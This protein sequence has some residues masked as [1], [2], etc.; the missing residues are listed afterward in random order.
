M[1]K[2]LESIAVNPQEVAD[3]ASNPLR[4]V[5]INTHS[6][7]IVSALPHDT[8]IITRSVREHGSTVAEFCCFDGTWRAK[9]EESLVKSMRVI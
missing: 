9:R 5:I 2:L 8:L 1:L 7:S 4:Q 6:P 3:P